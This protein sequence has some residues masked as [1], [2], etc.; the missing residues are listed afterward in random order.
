MPLRDVHLWISSPIRQTKH[1]A[2]AGLRLLKRA[3]QLLPLSYQTKAKHRQLIT[4]LFPRLMLASVGPAATLQEFALQY[5]KKW[6]AEIDKSTLP[7]PEQVFQGVSVF[8]NFSLPISDKPL[9]SVIVPIYGQINY[10]LR[11]LYSIAK[12][13][14]QVPFEVIVVDDCSPDQS[15]DVLSEMN[16]IR[17]IRNSENLGVVRSCNAGA[18]LGKGDY[19][20]FLNNNTEVMP[21]W[22]DE[23]VRTFV[24]FPGAGLVGSKLVYPDGHIQEAG[25]AIWQ[26]GRAWN[27]GRYQDL[28]L[29]ICNYARNVDYCSG[30]SIMVPKALFCD[31]GGF[32]EY[33]VPAYCEDSDLA[34]K[35]RSKGYRVIYQPLS[36]V[37]H[38]EGIACETDVTRGTKA[39][40]IENTRK[41]FECW[42]T[43]FAAH[44]NLGGDVDKAKDRAAH[45]RVL[46][47]DHCTPAP[48]Q[49]SGSIDAYNHMLLLRE[50]GFQV[51]FIPEDNFLYIFE[52]TSALQRIGIEVLYAPYVRSVKQHIKKYGKRYDLVFIYRSTVAARHLKAIRRF[53]TKAKVLF[54]TVDL[55]F[56]R[57]AREASLTSDRAAARRARKMKDLELS[58]MGD[59]DV[60][61]V[62]SVKELE[63]VKSML[64]EAK[65]RLLPY[66]RYIG[67][68]E[69]PFMERRDIVFVGGYQHAPNVDAVK[70]MV[71][72]IMPLLRERLPGIKF[73]IVG[74]NPPEEIKALAADDI[75]IVGFVDQLNYFLERMRVSVAPLRYGAGIK[76]KIG[77]AMA[78]GLPVVAT[79]VAA[80][81][82]SL[83][84]GENI[85]VADGAKSFADA[86]ARLYCDEDLWVRISKGAINFAKDNWGAE[87]AWNILANII[88][89]LNIKPIRREFP[90]KLYS[91]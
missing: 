37:I 53:C 78:I 90:L 48:N 81:G 59:S 91:E 4:K 88:S 3:Y 13:A 28:E 19:L 36:Q 84:H 56:L 34:L 58:L 70:F 69:V 68:T 62:V 20:L 42:Q 43:H 40:Q 17:L 64:P 50:M 82:M 60:T 11:C 27:F 65:V 26:D 22:M 2:K 39:Y 41:Q 30:A 29:P 1:Y 75:V 85:L 79:P 23:L 74:S 73:Y 45:Y 83:I 67:G 55:H 32:G 35:I 46:V 24:E 57:L 80:E 9:V 51:T 76:G 31:L 86:V 49:D 52:Y 21:H 6:K 8:K 54:H 87:A 12:H 72:E 47:L 61:T 5:N 77:T 66:A 38:Y 63:M 14:S 16:G 10:T 18:A 25:G 44:R 7:E 15:S 71:M 89:D 33:Y